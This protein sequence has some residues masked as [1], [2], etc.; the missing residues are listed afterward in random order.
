M[1][2]WIIVFSGTCALIARAKHRNVVHWAIYGAIFG[3]LAFLIII[4]KKSIPAWQCV[5]CKGEVPVD[6]SKCM[7]CG[8]SLDVA[9]IQ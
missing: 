7:H 4:F 2:L 6:A 1:A 3:V 5:A 8:S 9:L